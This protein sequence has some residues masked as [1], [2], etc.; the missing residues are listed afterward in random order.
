VTVDIEAHVSF[1]GYSGCYNGTYIPGTVNDATAPRIEAI[2]VDFKNRKSSYLCADGDLKMLLELY[3]M[4]VTN[5]P[6]LQFYVEP[7]CPKC[8]DS[9]IAS[10][11]ADNIVYSCPPCMVASAQAFSYSLR[12][13]RGYPGV[14]GLHEKDH[15]FVNGS[16]APANPLKVFRGEAATVVQVNLMPADYIN[17]QTSKNFQTYRL[18][19]SETV[20]GSTQGFQVD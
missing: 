9:G 1:I 19:Y 8:T 16:A 10:R 5:S 3:E 20:E 18:V 15:N 12:S 7:T 11:Y 4:K 2:G 13:T 6:K 17:R 14:G